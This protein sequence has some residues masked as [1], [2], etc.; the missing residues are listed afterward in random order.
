MHLFGDPALRTLAIGLP[1]CVLEQ[2][3]SAVADVF[4]PHLPRR[5]D[6][7][8]RDDAEDVRIVL[9]DSGDR[10]PRGQVTLFVAPLPRLQVGLEIGDVLASVALVNSGFHGVTE[11]ARPRG[12]RWQAA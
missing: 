5:R 4:R 1:T 10:N 9:A 12:R 3:E 11:N 8:E 6:V 7:A 2:P